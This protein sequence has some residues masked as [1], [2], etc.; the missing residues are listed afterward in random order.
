[1]HQ[2]GRMM[3]NIRGLILEDPEHVVHLLSLQ[4]LK[5]PNLGLQIE[6]VGEV[7]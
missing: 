1:M 7:A 2:V 4:F 6:E 3:M 5:N